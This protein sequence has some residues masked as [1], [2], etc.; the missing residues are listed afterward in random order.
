MIE[1]GSHGLGMDRVAELLQYSK[2]T[3]YNHF[4]CKEEIIIALAI[5]T[6]EKRTR[7]LDGF[8]WKPVLVDC[9]YDETL[10][11]IQNEVFPD[12]FRKISA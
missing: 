12:E 10:V 9:D 5:Q 2:G 1:H 11:R 8:G 3:I 6:T 7:M 4:S